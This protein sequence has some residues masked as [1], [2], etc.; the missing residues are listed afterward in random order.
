MGTHRVSSGYC[1]AERRV[2]PINEVLKKSTTIGSVTE[3][4]ALH[5]Q[6][7]KH[8]FLVLLH[9][10]GDS[11][12]MAG[13]SASSYI[14]DWKYHPADKEKPYFE[15]RLRYAPEAMLRADGVLNGPGMFVRPTRVTVAYSSPIV[16]ETDSDE[17][18]SEEDHEPKYEHLS[19]DDD[20]SKDDD[21]SEDED[22]SDDDDQNDPSADDRSEPASKTLSPASRE[23]TE[24]ATREDVKEEKPAIEHGSADGDPAESDEERER[25]IAELEVSRAEQAMQTVDLPF[26]GHSGATAGTRGRTPTECGNPRRAEGREA[27]GNVYDPCQDR[28]PRGHEAN[29][30]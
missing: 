27:T 1:A 24:S 22:P 25:E 5:P 19:E 18:P 12:A 11:V 9:R 28:R 29:K 21:S 4:V 3:S 20:S 26:F 16:K 7:N 23:R 15:M 2:G 13:S 14:S 30:G 17:E 6:K 10:D 8:S